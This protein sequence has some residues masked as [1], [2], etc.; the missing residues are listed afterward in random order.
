LLKLLQD[1]AITMFTAVP[2]VFRLVMAL[3]KPDQ[4]FPA[5]RLLRLAGDRTTRIDVELFK[6]HFLDH[7]LLRVGLG[8]SEVL[9]FAHFYIDRSYEMEGEVAPVGYELED[10]EL[11]LLDDDGNRVPPG[12]YGEIAVRSRYLSVG[13]WKNPELT[14]ERFRADPQDPSKGLYLSRDI[15]YFDQHGRLHH[16]GR[17]DSRLKLYGK[18]VLISDV[19]EALL[20]IEGIKEAVVLPFDSGERGTELAAFVTA[21]TPIDVVDI[22]KH[23]AGKL[24]PD[25][26]P[27]KILL[28]DKLPLQLN[29]K[30]N[31][32][33]LKELATVKHDYPPR[34]ISYGSGEA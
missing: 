28:L 22:R 30:I 7:C 6:Q 3:A 12:G 23:L 20:A 34:N 21:S 2:T 31:R 15:G 9:M 26:L 33:K 4:T 8:A 32:L 29:N 25:L 13:Y 17:K 11:L 14:G 18:M 16:V 24:A 27:R 5:M 1:G 19:E 10:L